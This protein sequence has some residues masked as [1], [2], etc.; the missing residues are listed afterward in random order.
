[1]KGDL[2]VS[3]DRVF[4]NATKNLPENLCF[5]GEPYGIIGEPYDIAGAGFVPNPLISRD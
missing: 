1:M 3:N 4:T 2:T 5:V